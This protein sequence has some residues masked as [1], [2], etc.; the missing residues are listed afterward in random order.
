MTA[1]L[2]NAPGGAS[3]WL[4]LA[5]TS[6]AN[7]SYTTFIY[8][9]AGVTTKTWTVKMPTTP[10]TYEF[11]LFANNGYT[12]L[13]TSPTVTVTNSSGNPNAPPPTLSVNTTTVA[14]R[15]S[16]TVTLTDGAGGQFDW[17]GFAATTAANSSYITFTY[18]G[19]G[20]TTRTW[21]ITAPATPG[22]YEFRLFLNNGYTRAATSLP[23]V[24]Q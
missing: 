14:P 24:V 15:G 18:V 5:A 12:R 7:T 22:T 6:A 2:T 21:T 13:A 4:A 1:T 16:L 9:G 19:A 20:V 8:V 23:I 3:D 17:L 10:G 11:R